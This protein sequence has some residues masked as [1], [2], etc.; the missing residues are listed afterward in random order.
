MIHM[1]PRNNELTDDQLMKSSGLM[2]FPFSPAGAVAPSGEVHLA[3]QISR[4]P[5]RLAPDPIQRN[6]PVARLAATGGASTEMARP[7]LIQ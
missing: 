5:T 3:S 1:S 4:V 2:S 7:G 6:R